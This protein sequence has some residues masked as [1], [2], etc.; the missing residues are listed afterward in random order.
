MSNY[1][2]EH[3]LEALKLKDNYTKK[4]IKEFLIKLTDDDFNGNNTEYLLDD[5]R[6]MLDWC[7][8]NLYS[9]LRNDIEGLIKCAILTCY[10]EDSYYT[11][12]DLKTIREESYLIVSLALMVQD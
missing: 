7:I 5:G 12:L 6:S 11:K 8:E 4:E 3:K 9:S 10:E 1:Y 2:L